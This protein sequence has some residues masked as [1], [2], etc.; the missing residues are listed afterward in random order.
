MRKLL[1]TLLFLVFVAPV[2]ALPSMTVDYPEQVYQNEQFTISVS[3]KDLSGGLQNIQIYREGFLQATYLCED[4]FSCSYDWE[5]SEADV[6]KVMYEVTAYS[7]YESG[8]ATASKEFTIE[9][10]ESPPNEPPTIIIT[11][12]DGID[13]IADTS[14]TI[15]WEDSD[16]DDDAQISLFYSDDAFATGTLI[17]AGL[18]E[19]SITDRYPWDTSALPNN[20]QYLIYAKIYDSVNPVVYY[21]NY[22][23]ITIIHAEEDLLPIAYA[24]ANPSSG[25]APLTVQFIGSAASGDAPLSYK[26]DFTSDGMIDSNLQN[27]IY[28]YEE[29]GTYTAT[30]TVTDADGDSDTAT[31]TITVESKARKGRYFSTGGGKGRSSIPSAIYLPPKEERDVRFTK[32]AGIF[33]L[34]ESYVEIERGQTQKLEIKIKNTGDIPA[35]YNIGIRDLDEIATYKIEPAS[36]TLYPNQELTVYAYLTIADDAQLGKHIATINLKSDSSLLI[37]QALIIDVLEISPHYQTILFG[38]IL[39]VV[40]LITGLAVLYKA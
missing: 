12:P 8:D 4:E 29:P 39:I 26:W 36:T 11:E 24:S 5:T 6:G 17:V 14:Y 10:L 3:V 35:T 31:T 30:L 27:S 13:D 19:D 20:T 25:I 22:N 23:P 33:D 21:F 16:P 9:V 32:L 18:S 28:T 34:L 7:E 40:A 2:Y 1:L 38:V 37:A 15:R